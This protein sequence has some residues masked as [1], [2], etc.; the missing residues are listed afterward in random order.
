MPKLFD[1]YDAPDI[2]DH[3]KEIKA[4]GYDA[5]A[6][7]YF[8]QSAFK[9]QLTRPVA[10]ALSAA[11]L[12]IVSLYENGSPT[13]AG[14]FTPDRGAHDGCVAA[15][16]AVAAGQ[17]KSTII[18][19]TV[20]YDAAT[21]DVPVIRAYFRALRLALTTAGYTTGVYGSG[22]V[23]RTLK[24]QGLV[25]KTWLSQS[26]G[27][28]GYGEWIDHADIVQARATRLFGAD[29]DLDTSALS[30]GGGWKLL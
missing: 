17:P 21:R 22:L 29:V 9:R 24:E 16:K 3:A 18:Y 15:A 28:Q 26:H 6:L 13:T 14:Y 12:F 19:P 23:C 27:W 1:A 10:E 4:A 25:T 11:G 30:G 20:D 8:E 2:A 7:Y 5:A